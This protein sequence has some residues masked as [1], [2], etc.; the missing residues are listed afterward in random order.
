MQDKR[1]ATYLISVCVDLSEQLSQSGISRGS[2]LLLFVNLGLFQLVPFVILLACVRG[3][4]DLY[5]ERLST[6]LESAY[7][8]AQHWSCTW[9]DN[10]LS[11]DNLYVALRHRRIVH[12]GSGTLESIPILLNGFL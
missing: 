3:L 2:L 9:L 8:P 12:A 10:I 5:K 1:L 6:L 4:G 7:M 11:L